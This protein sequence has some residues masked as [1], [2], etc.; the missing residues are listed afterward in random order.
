[1]NQHWVPQ[2]YFRLFSGG[3]SHIQLLLKSRGRIVL[4]APIK[5]Q[6]AR[7]AFYGP[8]EFETVLSRL[9]STDAAVMRRAIAHAWNPSATVGEEDHGLLCRACAIQRAR[10]L[11]EANKDV[12]LLDSVALYGFR[13]HIDSNPGIEH[14]EEMLAAIDAGQFTVNHS[15]RYALALAISES[16]RA[17]PLLL[18]LGVRLLRNQTDYPFIF[19]DAPVVL[20]NPHLK[21]IRERGVLGLTSPGLIVVWP[22]DSRTMLLLLDEAAYEGYAV[23]SG[24]VDLIE[25]ADV[26]QLNALQLHHSEDV[27]YFAS[28]AAKPYVERLWNAHRSKIV[29]PRIEFKERTG[30][31]VDGKP[32]EGPLMHTFEPQLNFSLALTVLRPRSCPEE[33][34]QFRRRNPE[35][36][37]AFQEDLADE[38]REPRG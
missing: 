19:G 30:W 11:L 3:T 21:K 5:G 13:H 4:N 2:Y 6:C 33:P 9:E 12:T 27:V 22:L 31:L 18:D 36:Y 37:A 1:M 24:I 10:T 7:R 8:Q 38:S 32:T 28:P 34:Y 16:L 23:E 25:R 20:V 29:R 14:R 17:S 15:H 26:S 35:F